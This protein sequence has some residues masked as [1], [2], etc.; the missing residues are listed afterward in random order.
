MNLCDWVRFA[1]CLL[2]LMARI[3]EYADSEP[4]RQGGHVMQDG[5]NNKRVQG[6]FTGQWLPSSLPYILASIARK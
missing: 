6:D 2:N 1:A 3:R 5:P 4:E